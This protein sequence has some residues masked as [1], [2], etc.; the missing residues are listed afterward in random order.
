[1]GGVGGRYAAPGSV[2]PG[3]CAAEAAV[4]NLQGTSSG[5]YRIVNKATGNCLSSYGALHTGYCGSQS[6]QEWRFGPNGSVV[7]PNTGKRMEESRVG[8]TV[9]MQK[10]DGSAVQRWARS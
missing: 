10:C 1:M 5:T 7:A 6:G 2:R 3:S 4:W 8:G 9:M